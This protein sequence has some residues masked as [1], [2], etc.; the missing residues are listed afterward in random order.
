MWSIEEMNTTSVA[1]HTHTQS[2]RDRKYANYYHHHHHLKQ[3]SSSSSKIKHH[4]RRSNFNE[5]TNQ[6]AI[7][8]VNQLQISKPPANDRG[9]KQ[10]ESLNINETQHRQYT[11]AFNFN[12][13]A[14]NFQSIF[15]SYI[16]C[17][18]CCCSAPFAVKRWYGGHFL[19]TL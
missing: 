3:T 7:E 12:L 17:C 5:A 8:K 14:T 19:S 2:W 10:K 4:H 13:Y 11:M 9:R 18:C 1:A 6:T 16:F 15:R